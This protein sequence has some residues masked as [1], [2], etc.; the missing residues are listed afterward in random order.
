MRTCRRARNAIRALAF[1]ALAVLAAPPPSTAWGLR[2]HR[3]VAEAAAARLPEPLRAAFAS[4]ALVLEDAAV[5]PDVV[6]RPRDGEREAIR[7]YLH[8]D[9]WGPELDAL[10]SLS[11]PLAEERAGR[12]R[13]RARG[14]LL[15]VILDSR[16]EV[17]LAIRAGDWDR[18]VV[19]AGHGAHYLS[20]GFM[21]LH[22]TTVH[23]G[24]GTAAGPG[25]HEA[26]ERGLVDPRIDEI[27]ARLPEE[28]TASAPLD[29]PR[30]LERLREVGADVP[31]LLSA[32]ELAAR[33]G[34]VGEPAYLEVLGREALPSLERRIADAVAGVA[35]FWLGAW[36]AAGEPD[37]R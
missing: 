23:D 26:I 20:D 35:S 25:L 18:A 21:P 14:T 8:L 17:T 13:L 30:I 9:A 22:L 4:R 2:T 31:G 3:L 24:Q 6:L 19:A 37:P 10:A 7:H 36:I 29:G 12:N 16:R 33:S 11:L 28:P 32:H 1:V 5:A 27:L 34:A 15:W